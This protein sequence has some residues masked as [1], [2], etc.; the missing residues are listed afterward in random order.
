MKTTLVQ[1]L[2]IAAAAMTT[3]LAALPSHAQDVRR[4]DMVTFFRMDHVDA[5][6]DGMVSRKEFMDMMGK[7]WDEMAAKTPAMKDKDKMTL[8]QYRAFSKMFNLDIGA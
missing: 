1:A 5:N 4:E 3:A 8:E 2:A 6:K 7:A